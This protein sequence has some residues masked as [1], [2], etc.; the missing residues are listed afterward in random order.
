[1]LRMYILRLKVHTRMYKLFVAVRRLA[2]LV[3]EK[4][5]RGRSKEKAGIYGARGGSQRDE[6]EV[7]RRM[8]ETL[9]EGTC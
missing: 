3:V 6:R 9:R 2:L 8:V 7:P 5:L 1:M 4:N